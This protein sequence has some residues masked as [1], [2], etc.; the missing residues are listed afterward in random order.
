M[1]CVDLPA[2]PLQLLLRRYPEWRDYPVVVVDSDKP[3]G[4]ILWVNEKAR[5]FCIVP[6]LRYTAALSLCATLRAGEVSELEIERETA[7]ISQNLQHFSPDVEPSCS[8]PG[9]FWLNAT[10]LERLYESFEGWAQRLQLL[11]RQRERLESKVVVGFSRFATWA[12]AKVCRGLAVFATQSQEYEAAL[13]VP[14]ERFAFDAKVRDSLAKL[15]VHTV[16]DFVALPADGIEKR[17]GNEV[18]RIYLEARGDLKTPLEPCAPQLRRRRKIHLDYSE[19][20]LIRLM[21]VIDDLLQSLVIELRGRDEAL[22]ILQVELFFE[23]GEKRREQLCPAAPTIDT[24]QISELIYLRLSSCKFPDGV[25]DLVLTVEGVRTQRQQKDL[26]TPK[27]LRDTAAA[28]RA[29]ARIRAEFGEQAVVRG[30]LCGGHLPEALFVW[31]RLEGVVP[32]VSS[33]ETLED[34]EVRSGGVDSAGARVLLSP[35]DLQPGTGVLVRRIYSQPL[36][37]PA[38]PRHEPDGWMLR[39]LEHG[40]VVR[41][42]GPYTISGGW[43]RKALQREYHFAE[44]QSG[45][46]LWVYYDRLR[47]RWFLQGKVE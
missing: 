40:P 36:L 21:V 12:L 45:N 11:L 19:N 39:G 26:F 38:R 35:N 31:E 3:Q 4:R 22:T 46:L 1:A 27:P 30:R 25:T 13:R 23:G 34:Q 18:W 20:D 41:V 17:F 33:K 6:G 44:T 5:S 7:S 14:L 28:N 42:L 16:G 15:G 47:R 43:W 29:L 32:I 24:E 9:V 10:G 2:F 37:L 8:D